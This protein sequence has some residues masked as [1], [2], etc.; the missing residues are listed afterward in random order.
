M[1]SFDMPIAANAADGTFN[2]CACEASEQ[3]SC[4]DA[5]DFSRNIGQIT[6]TSRANLGRD[7]M[8]QAGTTTSLEVTGQGL[9]WSTDRIAFVPCHQ[10]CGLER[11][12]SCAITSPFGADSNECSINDF[13]KWVARH[14]PVIQPEDYTQR[15][16]DTFS[17]VPNRYCVRNFIEWADAHDAAPESNSAHIRHVALGLGREHSC[18]A[19]CALA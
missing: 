5:S 13:S 4:P 8:L 14:P 3:G 11:G 16:L 6:I 2:I 18:H 15:F 12:V 17:K 19:K 10:S 7:Y 1:L 9:D